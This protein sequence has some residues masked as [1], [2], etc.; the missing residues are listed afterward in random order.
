MIT[1]VLFNLIGGVALL[2][3]G[4]REMAAGMEKVASDRLRDILSLFTRNRFVAVMAGAGLTALVQSSSASTILVVGFVNANLLS[5]R[6]AVGVIMGANIGTTVTGWLV[7]LFAAFATFK[8]TQYTLPAIAVGFFLLTYGRRYSARYWGQFIFGFGMLFLGLSFMKDGAD[9][10]KHS[11]FLK[12]FFVWCAAYPVLGVLAG[13]VFTIALQSSSATI[14]ILQVL[15]IQGLVPFEAALPILLGDNIGT[16]ITAQLASWSVKSTTARRAAMAHSLFNVLGTCWALPLIYMGVFSSGVETLLGPAEPARMATFIAVSHSLF[17]VMNTL[18]F[19]PFVNQLEWAAKRLT[20]RGATEPFSGPKFLDRNMLQA[21]TLA[22]NG[23]VREMHY[24]LGLARDGLVLAIQG[25]R[26]NTDNLSQVEA[27]EDNVDS[28]QVDIFRYLTELNQQE[29]NESEASRLPRI[30]HV[31]NDIEKISDYG[32]RLMRLHQRLEPIHNDEVMAHL[33][34]IAALTVRALDECR[35]ALDRE[36]DGQAAARRAQDLCVEIKEL[37][38]TLK[39]EHVARLSAGTQYV[40]TEQVLDDAVDYLV[41]TRAHI[42]NVA[43][44]CLSGKLI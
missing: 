37:S 23:V 25:V 29:L 40:S 9:P 41:S 42:S 14:A 19:L 44:S 6:Q 36:E 30:F 21:P 15:A 31:V 8:I 4:M 2:F 27:L 26:K 16:T 20:P 11:E 1:T 13:V 32:E 7:A 24:M 5:L 43:E 39:E 33:D 10:L 35:T 17:N 38:L 28:L 34:R 3:F 12:D 22:L 18:M